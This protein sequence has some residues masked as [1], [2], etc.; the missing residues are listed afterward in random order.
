MTEI[1]PV[2]KAP[3]P[4]APN[5]WSAVAF[6]LKQQESRPH[7][8]DPILSFFV[9]LTFCTFQQH[10]DTLQLPPMKYRFFDERETAIGHL[11][12]LLHGSVGDV[13]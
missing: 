5:R 11:Q 2:P 3:S 12:V 10:S 4:K 6:R 1:Q 13:K 7:I 9:E 8:L